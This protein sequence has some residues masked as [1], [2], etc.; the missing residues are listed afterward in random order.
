MQLLGLHLEIECG[1]RKLVSLKISS[2]V[3][4]L[5]AELVFQ[6]NYNITVY[7][8]GNANEGMF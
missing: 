6:I 8:P 2:Y 5:C 7:V 4:G 1:A 3:L